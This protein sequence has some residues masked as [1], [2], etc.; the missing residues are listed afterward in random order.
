VPTRASAC[1][2]EQNVE[3]PAAGSDGRGIAPPVR[4][5]G[6]QEVV[7]ELAVWQAVVRWRGYHREGGTQPSRRS[8]Q[9]EE[10]RRH[11]SDGLG[12]PF[13]RLDVGAHRPFEVSNQR[14]FPGGPSQV[15]GPPPLEFTECRVGNRVAGFD[16]RTR[17]RAEGVKFLVGQPV[18]RE[19]ALG[20]VPRPRTP[21]HEWP[22]DSDPSAEA[23]RWAFTHGREQRAGRLCDGSADPGGLDHAGE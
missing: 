7:D 10:A 15:L 23:T 18:A 4:P 19:P 5:E 20:D 1:G 8:G 3:F 2:R 6:P 12:D 14:R 16:G 9:G 11:F 22:D 13:R 17:V 21:A